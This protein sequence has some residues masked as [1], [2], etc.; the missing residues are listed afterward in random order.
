[1]LGGRLISVIMP[2]VFANGHLLKLGS[3]RDW[4]GGALSPWMIAFQR[5]D[6]Q[7]LRKHILGL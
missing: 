7:V 2:P 1:M 4:E 3:H 6:S 5:D